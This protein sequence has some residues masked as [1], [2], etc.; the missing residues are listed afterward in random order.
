M[1][2]LYKIVESEETVLVLNFNKQPFN[3]QVLRYTVQIAHDKGLSLWVHALNNGNT[4]NYIFEPLFKFEEQFQSLD[5][6]IAHVT[7][8]Q[9]EDGE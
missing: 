8:L 9:S 7:K 1:T 6:A 4:V 2:K 5:E 3:K